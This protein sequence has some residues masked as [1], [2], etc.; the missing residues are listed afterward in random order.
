MLVE[1]IS[2]SLKRKQISITKNDYDLMDYVK[3][4]GEGNESKFILKCVRHYKERG[5]ALSKNDVKRMIEEY[6]EDEKLDRQN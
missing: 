4:Q 3:E 5:D 1:V 2:L 6:I